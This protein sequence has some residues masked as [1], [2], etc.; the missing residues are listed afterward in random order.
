MR[1]SHLFCRAGFILM[2]RFVP[3]NRQYRA[4]IDR[5][6]FF[7]LQYCKI[8]NKKFCPGSRK[9]KLLADASTTRTLLQ[10]T[11][12]FCIVVWHIVQAITITITIAGGHHRQTVYRI[13]TPNAKKKKTE[14]RKTFRRPRL[15]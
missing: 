15:G 5:I 1:L 6:F 3:E 8:K 4:H 14:N 7:L 11:N 13:K 10:N 12:S 9:D 2:V